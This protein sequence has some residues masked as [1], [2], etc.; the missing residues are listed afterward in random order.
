MTA[1]A[2]PFRQGDAVDVAVRAEK[3]EYQGETRLS[4]Q[5]RDIRPADSDDDAVFGSEYLFGCL[6]RGEPLSAA[7]RALLAPDRALLGKIYKL[8]RSEGPTALPAEIMALRVGAPP[9]KTGAVEVCLAALTEVG[10]LSLA[11]G[12]YADAAPAGKAD[13]SQSRLLKML[14]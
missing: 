3:N 14:N 12:A 5:V 4:L 11:D 8:V 1:E 13:L 2:F 7:D 10:V 6:L 9:E